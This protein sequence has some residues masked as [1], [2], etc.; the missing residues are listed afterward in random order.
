[1]DG[2]GLAQDRY[3]Q[4][5]LFKF[6]DINSLS[7]KGDSQSQMEKFLQDWDYLVENLGP[8]T[9]GAEALRDIFQS[10]WS[11]PTVRKEDIAHYKRAR[12]KGPGVDAD[13]ILEVMRV[14]MGIHIN[15]QSEQLNIIEIK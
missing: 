7:W 10:K 14:S 11:N 8:N 9:M 6:E 3:T 15:D 1:M 4:V 12:A 13:Y 2:F 5:H